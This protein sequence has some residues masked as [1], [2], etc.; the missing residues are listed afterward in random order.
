MSTPTSVRDPRALLEPAV[1]SGVV[2]T[3]LNNNPGMTP[4]L[5]ERIT[6]EALKFLAAAA[7]TPGSPIAPSPVVD[8]GWHALVLDTALYGQLCDRLGV[9]LHHRPELPQDVDYDP[10]LI[11]RTLQAME[12]AG[13]TPDRQLWAGPDGQ[14]FAVAATTWHSP[15]EGPIVIIP[16]PPSKSHAA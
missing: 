11:A 4:E 9:F 12:R 3:V 6:A 8:E 10:Q 16:K 14:V 15:P 7:N 2:S 13:Y 5:A 1:F